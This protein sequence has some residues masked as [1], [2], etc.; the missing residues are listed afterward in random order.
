MKRPVIVRQR[1]RS[2]CGA[3]C[4]A[5]I[6]ACYGNPLSVA[7]VRQL[8]GTTIDGT[9]MYGLQKA[10]TKIGFD[11]TGIRADDSCLNK[12]PLPAIAHVIRK[13]GLHHYVVL[14]GTGKKRYKIMDPADGTI[15]RIKRDDFLDEWS[16]ILLTLT[17]TAHDQSGENSHSFLSRMIKLL[18][19]HRSLLIQAMAGAALY[20]IAGLSTAIFVQLIIDYVIADSNQKLLHLFGAAMVGILLFKTYVGAFKSLYTIRTGQ[21]IDAEL[22]LGYYRHILKLPLEFFSQMQ[23]GEITSRLGDAVRIRAFVNDALIHI[24]VQLFVFLFAFA[25]MFTTYWKLALFMLLILPVYTVIYLIVNRRNRKTQREL[26]ISGARLETRLVESIQAIPAIK[27]L[28]LEVYTEE[29]SEH[30]FIKLLRSIYDSSINMLIA[31][32]SSEVISSAFTILVLW[33]GTLFVLDG[34]L[35]TGELLSFYTVMGYFTRPVEELLGLN[36]TIQDASIAGDRLFDILDLE[37]ENKSS[38]PTIPVTK[39]RMTTIQFKNVRF[40]YRP[41]REILNGLS[42]SIEKGRLTALVGESGSGK[43]TV[44]HLIQKLYTPESGDIYMGDIKLEEL[45]TPSFRA[46]MGV[47]PQEV[48]LFSGTIADNIAPGEPAPDFEKIHYLCKQTGL[49]SLIEQLPKGI[50]T[51]L[52]SYGSGLSSGEKQRLS[53]AR[54]L[55]RD[56]ELFLLDEPT[57]SLDFESE[58]MIQSII[59]DLR[60][61]GK[62]VL[63]AA[64]RLSTVTSA[65]QICILKQG[66]VAACGTHPELLSDSPLYK[67][68]WNLQS[69]A[70]FTG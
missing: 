49:N 13:G 8:A 10:A 31:S 60:N 52:G 27:R 36:Q 39:S 41:E 28:G 45:D 40:G 35:T 43:S 47:V 14:Y 6:A 42:L 50:H 53:F 58:A 48:S 21:L 59:L 54:A 69:P 2:D 63:V 12:L 22:M 44:T 1:D 29:R 32:T 57:A 5:S 33:I 7:R 26:M 66:I 18:K 34:A 3:A 51:T 65:D 30:R 68:L 64:H 46:C 23:I 55:Y 17:P 11:A 67:R 15:R 37:Q 25:L 19:P 70:H 61:R 16:G 20:T 9:S 56:P 24:S 62:T 38:E 4:L